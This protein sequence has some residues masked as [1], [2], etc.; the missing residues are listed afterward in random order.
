MEAFQGVD[1]ADS[2]VLGWSLNDGTLSFDIDVSLWPDHPGYIANENGEVACYRKARLI[3]S[4]VRDLQG[5]RPMEKTEGH[6][7]DG[8]K[9]YGT[10][11]YFAQ[12]GRGSFVLAGEF[13]DVEFKS[14]Q[15]QLELATQNEPA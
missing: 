13:G 3:F 10:I 6:D 11:D 14:D 7:F 5:L 1:L 2:L 8:V 4:S 15:P 9:D 12:P